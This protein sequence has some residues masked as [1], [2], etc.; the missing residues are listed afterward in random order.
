MMKNLLTSAL[1]LVCLVFPAVAHGGSIEEADMFHAQGKKL[2]EAGDYQLALDKYTQAYSTYPQAKYVFAIA[3]AYVKLGNLPRALD[4]YEM[5]TQYEPTPE[6]LAR[7]QKETVTLKGLLSQE[8]GEVF[9]FSSPSEAQIIIDEISKQNV[10]QTPAR[11]WLKEGPHSIFFKK[12]NCIPREIKVDVK[13][14]EHVY[15]YAGLKKS[16]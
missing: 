9:V 2:F 5:F 13:K 4:A 8:Y 12:E 10:Y 16:E 7:V 15:I 14:G 11:R 3:A 1:V 6:V